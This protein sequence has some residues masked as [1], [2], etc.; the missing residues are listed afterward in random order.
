[1]SQI[2]SSI[3]P[4]EQGLQING[5]LTF[6]TVADLLEKGKVELGQSKL[7]SV[8]VNLEN[9]KRID[10]AGISLLLEWKRQCSQ[11]KKVLTFEGIQKQAKSLIKTYKLQGL[12]R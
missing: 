8:V 9:I 1:M 7:D 2:I 6:D 3:T 4:T 10:S 12:L 11:N 5:Q